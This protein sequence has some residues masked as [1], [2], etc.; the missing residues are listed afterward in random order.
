MNEI[1]GGEPFFDRLIWRWKDLVIVRGWKK[2]RVDPKF[3]KMN[4]IRS[5]VHGSPFLVA[6]LASLMVTPRRTLT[7]PYDMASVYW[8]FMAGFRDITFFS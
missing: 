2:F 6:N 5:T 7:S 3:G 8:M 4:R 1:V